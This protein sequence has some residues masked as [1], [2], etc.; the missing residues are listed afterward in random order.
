MLCYIRMKNDFSMH[1]PCL[2]L[3]FSARLIASKSEKSSYVDSTFA[4]VSKRDTGDMNIIN[5]NEKEL[6][7]NL[8]DNIHDLVHSTKA[9]KTKLMPYDIGSD[10]NL[11]G[12][13]YK[14][15][16]A[17]N[18]D[19]RRRIDRHSV[20]GSLGKRGRVPMGFYGQLGKRAPLGFYS[21]LGKRAPLGF[22]SQLGKRMPMGFFG[23]LGK[24][25]TRRLP[26]SF[27]SQLGKRIP[28]GFVSQLGKRMPMGFMSQLG[29]R[30]G[31][32]ES[33]ENV[34]V[35]K[36]RSIAIPWY[37][38]QMKTA[39]PSRYIRGGID[40]YSFFSRLGKRSDNQTS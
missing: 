12:F 6:L 3:I 13:E 40:R 10:Y 22:R 27:V 39:I 23:Q 38:A 1:V 37:F 28:M 35:R 4:K 21:Q 32:Q 11:G 20:V 31:D 29:K 30:S 36:R 33:D 15:N 14:S 7:H 26:M 24:R 2:I 17:V 34:Y 16:D 19:N 18:K 9:D 25:A 5:A 8:E